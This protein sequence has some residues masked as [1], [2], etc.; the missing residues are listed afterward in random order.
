MDMLKRILNV[1]T[2][3]WALW[4]GGLILTILSGS[5]GLASIKQSLMDYVYLLAIVFMVGLP[6]ILV[7]NYIFFKK[8]TLWN[9]A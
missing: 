9:K 4:V 7:L 6:S 2:V 8:P 3:F 5:L 1:I